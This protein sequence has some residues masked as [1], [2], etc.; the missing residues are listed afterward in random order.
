MGILFI[1]YELKAIYIT[2]FLFF[3]CYFHSE[4][5]KNNNE[6]NLKSYEEEDNSN[7]LHTFKL[8]KHTNGT[9][10]IL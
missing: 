9:R 10:V 1:I 8:P 5:R 3:F 6:I 7:Y 4:N 2:L